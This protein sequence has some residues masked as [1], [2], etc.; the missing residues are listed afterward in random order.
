MHLEALEERT[1]LTG[2]VTAVL[3]VTGNL[4][5]QGDRFNNEITI[6]PSPLD[7]ARMIRVQGNPFTFSSVNSV[8]YIDFVASSIRA[9]TVNF[10]DGNNSLTVTGVNVPDTMLVSAGAGSNSFAM[11]NANANAVTFTAAGPGGDKVSLTNVKAGLVQITAGDGADSVT[12]QSDKIGAAA[13]LTSGGND[14]VTVAGPTSTVGNLTITSDNGDNNIAVTG[15]SLAQVTV[16]AGTGNGTG[17]NDV[18]FSSNTILTGVSISA[19]TGGSAVQAV[20]VSNN[21]FTFGTAGTALLVN[22]G[23]SPVVTQTFT[24]AQGENP[25]TH[26]FDA[27][28]VIVSGNKLSNNGGVTVQVGANA[29]NVNVSGNTIAKG[30]LNLTVGDSS[31]FSDGNGTQGPLPGAVTVSDNTLSGA[32][33]VGVGLTA[34]SVALSNDTAASLGLTVADG[35]QNVTLSKVITVGD[36][37]VSVGAGANAGNVTETNVSSSTQTL[38]VGDGANVSLNGITTTSGALTETVGKNSTDVS[39]VNVTSATDLGLTVGDGA[40]A[41]SLFAVTTG[42]NLTI[43]TGTADTLFELGGIQVGFDM[44][45]TTGD[46][47]NTFLLSSVAV[48]DG[49]FITAGSGLNAVSARKVTAFFGTFDT[50]PGGMNVFENSGGNSGFSLAGVAGGLTGPDPI[51]LS[52]GDLTLSA[53]TINEGDSVTLTGSFFQPNSI[54]GHTVTINWGEGSANTVLNLGRGVFSFSAPHQ[55]LDAT[56]DSSP[57]NAGTITVAVTDVDNNTLSASTAITVNNVPPVIPANGLTLSATTINEGD[58]VSLSGAFADP[59]IQD[60]HKV[61][62]DWGDGST[63]T[64]LSLAAGVLNFGP[65]SH[66]YLNNQPGDAPYNILVT[67]TDEDN[68]KGSASTPVTVQNVAPANLKLGLGSATIVKGDTATLNGTFTDPGVLDTHKVSIDWGDGSPAVTLNLAAGILT[69]DVSHQYQNAQPGDAPYA[70]QVT[71]IDSDGAS[72]SASTPVT[73]QSV[74]PVSLQVALLS[75]PINEGDTATLYGTITDPGSPGTHTVA[76]NWGDGSPTTSLS[77]AAGVL[78]FSASHPYLD[79]LPGDAPYTIAVTVT[80]ENN[81]TA[82]ASSSL[83]VKNVAPIA[84]AGSDQT[85]SPGTPVT[86]NAAFTDPGSADGHTFSWSVVSSNGQVV[87]NDNG[88]SFTF[89]PDSSGEYTVTL[90]VTDS[91]GGV[92]TSTTTVLVPITDLVAITSTV[93][94]GPDQTV[95]PGTPVTLNATFTD[96]DTA[97][98]STLSWSVAASN[99]QVIPNGSGPSFTFTPDQPGTYTV[100]LTAMQSSGAVGT[101]TA[102]IVV[103]PTNDFSIS[104][105]VFGDV[106]GD[107]VQGPGEAGQPGFTVYVDLNGNGQLDSGEP[108]ATTDANGNYSFT[109]LTAGNNTVRLVL[110]TPNLVLSQ[111]VQMSGSG[112]SNFGILADNVAY[113]VNPTA[114]LYGAQPND[115]A[116]TAFVKGLYRS[117]L[118]RDGD[119]AGISFW[120]IALARGKSRDNVAWAFVNATEHRR[121]QVN[122][123]Y[124][125]FLGRAATDDPTSQAWVDLLQETGDETVVIKGILTSAEYTAKH[126]SDQDFVSDL[127]FRLLGRVADADGVAS[128]VNQLGAGLSR[129]DAVDRFLHSREAAGL[130]VQ[131]LYAAFLHRTADP[132][133]ETWVTQLTS[134][135]LTYGRMAASFLAGS[136]FFL[137]AALTVP[138][139]GGESSQHPRSAATREI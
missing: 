96:P 32:L 15:T 4:T 53:T 34:N 104:G 30:N 92:G 66:A 23:D 7:P 103:P 21:T 83:T 109:D 76:I 43:T 110:P 12:L 60:T 130:A 39:L 16:A 64:T 89:T 49:M 59:G 136:E 42:N 100:T 11:V 79:N 26:S 116:N 85:V 3:D 48:A 13:I 95:P 45:F 44:N 50:G 72:T 127:Y 51:A 2:R 86:L 33:N 106:N 52:P 87:P 125:T 62:I 58:S 97:A 47:D 137:G 46:G 14:T 10:L 138:G 121:Q 135:A 56:S 8:A 38:T 88:P 73:V 129:A 20:N 19:G 17:S 132:T 108:T 5:I 112:G 9:V 126:A 80:N 84:D 57:P 54:D 24:N 117:V 27:A 25:V 115:D 28:A 71:V 93:S 139:Q 118:G 41:V 101:S 75:N 65:V 128:W 107:G 124:E 6:L 78:T 114:D 134:G 40:A 36:I 111:P 70:I 123:Y 82:S 29:L 99:G 122:A 94:A 37:T 63:A 74:A 120:V 68:G 22:V 90:T 55:Y 18:T 81:A 98:G 67:V 61:V 31:G 105:T 69:F 35:S 91:D 113:P 119:A 131:S 77:L 133:S 1:L 102:T